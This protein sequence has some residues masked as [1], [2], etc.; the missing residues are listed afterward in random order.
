MAG[1]PGAQTVAALLAVIDG[2]LNT[3]A[4]AQRFGVSPITL[5]KSVVYKAWRDAGDDET[6]QAIRDDLL[7]RRREIK[8]R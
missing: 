6:R 4:A 8:R 5:Y 1:K 2:K 3:H 7:N